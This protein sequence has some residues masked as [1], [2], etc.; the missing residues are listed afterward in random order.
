VL[1]A[2]WPSFQD[3]IAL[4]P[5]ANPLANVLIF[6][7]AHVVWL[8]IEAVWFFF[9]LSGFVL[10]K[11]ASRPG[12]S[13][14]AYYPSRLIRLY[15]PVLFAIALAWLSYRLIPHQAPPGASPY[16]TAL[17][18]GYPIADVLHD[19]TLLGGTSTSVGVLWSLQWEV[20]F[21]LLLPVYLL[22]VRKYPIP[23]AIIALAGALAGWFYVDQVL[24][25]MPLFF[26][27]ALLAQYW[28][29]VLNA[30]SFLGRGG[31]LSHL[32]G[33]L[34]VLLGVA[35]M[36]AFFELGRPLTALGLPPRVVTFPIVVAGMLLLVI[37]SV[38]WP[39]LSR[40]L[41]LRALVFLGTI[42]FSLY[43]VHRPIMI[44]MAY[45]FGLGTLSA[46]LA[47]VASVAVAIGFFYAFERPIH[48]LSQKVNA[49][50]RDSGTGRAVNDQATPGSDEVVR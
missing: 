9:I 10:T 45:T 16:L 14:S 23:A 42:S 1:A 8:G 35:A 46:V 22:L 33:T 24:M 36:T 2:N 12:F 49:R 30:F 15:G 39:P 4:K 7:P 21:S 41:T 37:T 31:W 25:Y 26:F 19:A 13:W 3:G 17:P 28:K 47:V 32:C 34:F 50:L 6:S 44:A 5:S 38:A 11:M 43:L 20:L 48:R 27:G 18:T 40:L 29:P